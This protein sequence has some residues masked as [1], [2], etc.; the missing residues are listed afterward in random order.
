M[1]NVKKFSP[2]KP[3]PR[4]RFSQPH[5]FVI[6][7]VLAVAAGLYLVFAHRAATNASS[8]NTYI[9]QRD[10][11]EVS[12]PAG[13]SAT[14][15]T[16]DIVILTHDLDRITI[17][18]LTKASATSLFPEAT[19]TITLHGARATRYHDVDS[20]TAQAIDRIVVERPDGRVNELR[21]IGTDFDTIAASFQLLSQKGLTSPPQ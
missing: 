17:A 7:G 15:D 9:N 5:A 10:G 1:L 11:Y 21:G 8:I 18:T 12:Y 13:W 14:T 2:I 4:V 6:V 19:T 3:R 16:N 20:A